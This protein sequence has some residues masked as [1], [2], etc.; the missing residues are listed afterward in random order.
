ML[1]TGNNIILRIRRQRG[2]EGGITGHPDHQ[3]AILI[4]VLLR[5]QQR[6][7]RH[8]VVL[9]MPALMYLEEGA[10]Q[11]HQFLLIGFILQRGRV[12]LLVKQYAAED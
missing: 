2:K 12:Q 10:Q 9:N 5:V 4:R 8:D 11:H 7:A 3:I 1:R 6:F